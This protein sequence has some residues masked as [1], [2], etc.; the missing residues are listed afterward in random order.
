MTML[1]MTMTNYKT[2]EIWCST[3]L[4]EIFMTGPY[5]K[6]KKSYDEKLVGLV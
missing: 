5:L 1:T 4:T 3:I 6:A 2:L